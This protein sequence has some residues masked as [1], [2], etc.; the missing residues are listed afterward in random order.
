M[1]ECEVQTMVNGLMFLT[2][3]QYLKNNETRNELEEAY[4]SGY[5]SD[6]DYYYTLSFLNGSNDVCENVI[7]CCE[8]ILQ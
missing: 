3:M 4:T 2:I 1:Q 8:A 6:N 7:E 5:M